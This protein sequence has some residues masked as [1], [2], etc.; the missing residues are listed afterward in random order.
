[1]DNSQTTETNGP[2]MPPLADKA[3]LIFNAQGNTMTADQFDELA[4]CVGKAL[5]LSDVLNMAANGDGDVESLHKDTLAMYS[6]ML[7]EV[8]R[9]ARALIDG[10]ADI[11]SKEVSAARAELSAT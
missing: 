1:M 2:K 7:Y 10:T 3:L 9:D 5:A 8:L 11:A 4:L 6:S